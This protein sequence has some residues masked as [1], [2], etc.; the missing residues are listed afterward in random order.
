[1]TTN[2]QQ[3]I[4]DYLELKGISD[5]LEL[6]GSL[7]TQ[8]TGPLRP[9]SVSVPLLPGTEDY[10]ADLKSFFD[11]MVW[12]LHKHRSKGYWG[13]VDVEGYFSKLQGEVE[14]LRVA[15]DSGSVA[16]SLEEAADTANMAM[17]IASAFM[18]KAVRR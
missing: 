12:K 14:E 1:M 5:Y 16:W 4:S 8:T 10:A 11:L 3:R 13:N 9:P 15:L 2:D 7:E 18:R 6:K 17:I